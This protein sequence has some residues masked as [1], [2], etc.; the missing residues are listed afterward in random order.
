[1]MKNN[2][3]PLPV[4]ELL[5]LACQYAIRDQE[6]FVEAM[7]NCTDDTGARDEAV[8]YL[9]QLRAYYRRRWLRPRTLK[10]PTK[11]GNNMDPID[12]LR[13]NLGREATASLT[14]T[15]TR[16]LAACHSILHLYAST[17]SVAVLVAYRAVVVEMQPTTR[18]MAYHLIA[19]VLDWSDRPVV[20]TQ[21]G[22]PAMPATLVRCKH[23]PNH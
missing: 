11:R 15:D 16:A 13:D 1:M 14:G 23:E 22:L 8:A 2:P 3:G 7:S 6:E 19:M 5:R 4:D 9:R 12:W 18:Y 10:Q 21:A 20:W 17:W